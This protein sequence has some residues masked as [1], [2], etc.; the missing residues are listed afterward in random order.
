MHNYW[1]IVHSWHLSLSLKNS[2]FFFP[3]MVQKDFYSLLYNITFS[4]WTL[5]WLL[6]TFQQDIEY[7]IMTKRQ[8][9]KID[10]FY[11]LTKNIKRTT[12]C[13]YKNMYI[14]INIYIMCH[15]FIV[16]MTFLGIHN[17]FYMCTLH[18][19]GIAFIYH[20]SSDILF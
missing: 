15:I 20:F 6:S 9:R 5:I 17:L 18:I 10:S 2:Y 13:L 12:T 3:K 14:H 4:L 19:N 16:I 8:F 11:K 1:N 7:L